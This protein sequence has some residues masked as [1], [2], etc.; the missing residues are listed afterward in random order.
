[1][2]YL[3][4]NTKSK[5]PVDEDTHFGNNFAKQGIETLAQMSQRKL[6]HDY[7]AL[8]LQKVSMLPHR[9]T[10][11]IPRGRRILKPNL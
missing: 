9:K 4:P 10:L 2:V 7:Q 1:M 6:C 8:W 3:E 11:E 5:F